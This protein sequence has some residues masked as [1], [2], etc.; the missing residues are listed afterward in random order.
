MDLC[1]LTSAYKLPRSGYLAHLTSVDFLI[2][3]MV[4]VFPQSCLIYSYPSNTY[5][6]INII[7][8]DSML[9]SP[10]AYGSGRKETERYV[11]THRLGS[12][13]QKQ[14][15]FASGQP[16]DWPRSSRYNR[17][18]PRMTS[19]NPALPPGAPIQPHYDRR[20]RDGA[21]A[22]PPPVIRIRPR[23]Q[24]RYSRQSGYDQHDHYGYP[25]GRAR[26]RSRSPIKNKNTKS[27]RFQARVSSSD[28]NSISHESYS[29]SAAGYYLASRSRKEKDHTFGISL[30]RSN[31]NKNLSVSLTQDSETNL[32]HDGA[33]GSRNNLEG[34]YKVYKENIFS[35]SSSRYTYSSD[36]RMPIEAELVLQPPSRPTEKSLSPLLTWM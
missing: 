31:S 24:P 17:R 9:P 4:K 20:M 12:E 22:R 6:T 14:S 1:A 3:Q 13:Y 11:I 15:V 7:S 36:L 16:Q 29:E 19:Y 23:N 34:G 21:R 2:T 32:G 10:A 8:M 25:E 27:I 28:D 33:N 5:S 35:V 30:A 26:R 18:G